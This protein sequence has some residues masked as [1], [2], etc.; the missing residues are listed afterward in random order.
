MTTKPEILQGLIDQ[1]V[2]RRAADDAK[3]VAPYQQKID[4]LVAALKVREWMGKG[5]E[6]TRHCPVC[7]GFE[8]EGHKDD[9]IVGLALAGA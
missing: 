7:R 2:A 4:L 5:Y 9:C 1:E 6:T 3:L 8:R